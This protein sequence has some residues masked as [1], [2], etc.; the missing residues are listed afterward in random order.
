MSWQKYREL[1]ILSR[2][3]LIYAARHGRN[4]TIAMNEPLIVETYPSNVPIFDTNEK[5]HF[6]KL[7]WQSSCGNA[8]TTLIQQ[9]NH[10]AC[11]VEFAS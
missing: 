2:I 9:N 8:L 6:S 11:I 5:N 3:K 10:Q 4:C 7:M 1:E